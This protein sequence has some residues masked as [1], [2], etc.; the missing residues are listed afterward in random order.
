MFPSKIRSG[1]LHLLKV[2]VEYIVYVSEPNLK[3]RMRVQL[4][5]VAGLD[6]AGIDG[7]GVFREF[8]S[9]LIKSS[10]DPNRGFFKTT[11]DNTLYPNP[12]AKLIH[13]NHLSHYY[14]MGR[15][16]GK[17]RFS[18]IRIGPM[19]H[20]QDSRRGQFATVNHL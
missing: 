2:E 4:K 3:L 6:E 17:V 19:S 7:G 5:N 20:F 8:L 14:F 13:D 12:H 18:K 1:N 15:I 11:V 9:Q 16:L 10:F